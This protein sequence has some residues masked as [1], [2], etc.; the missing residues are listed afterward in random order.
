MNAVK[1]KK[2]IYLYRPYSER[3]TSA[4]L[5][6]AFVTEN[7]RSVSK[8]ADS[9]VTKDGTIRTPNAAEVEISATSILPQGDVLISKL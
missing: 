3:T 9:T 4:A 6:M 1:G 5:A 7:S 2:L 8:D